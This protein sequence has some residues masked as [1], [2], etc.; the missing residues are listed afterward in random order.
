MRIFVSVVLKVQVTFVFS[1]VHVVVCASV[2]RVSV[3]VRVVW[4][5]DHPRSD[6]FSVGPV[7]AS[8]VVVIW[9]SKVLLRKF[10]QSL[11]R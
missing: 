9:Q 11:L 10:S 2:V 7:V 1:V 4:K 5:V 8:V 3:P 6:S